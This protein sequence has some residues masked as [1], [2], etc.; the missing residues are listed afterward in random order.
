M[1]GGSPRTSIELLPGSRGW[2]TGTG[3]NRHLQNEGQPD[4]KEPAVTKSWVY[5][6][7]AVGIPTAALQ[8]LSLRSPG[9]PPRPVLQ[10]E[11]G[12]STRTRNV[13]EPAMG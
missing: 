10:R 1:S 7:E 9:Y 6:L 12:K 2:G 8:N 5:G 3:R 4:L 11:L 13:L